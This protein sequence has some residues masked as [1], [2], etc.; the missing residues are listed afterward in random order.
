MKPILFFCV[1]LGL[2]WNRNYPTLGADEDPPKAAP[3]KQVPTKQVPTKQV[4]T[5]QVPQPGRF[6][7]SVT[8]G[9]KVKS[10]P[11]PAKALTE[12]SRAVARAKQAKEG[13]APAF[14]A[15]LTL[16]DQMF[17]FSDPEAAL[18]A[19]KALSTAMRDLPKLR[20]GLGDLGEIPEAK[21]ET[22]PQPPGTTKQPTG[23]K[24][25]AAAMAEVRRRINLAL[26]RQMVGSGRGSYGIRMPN[27]ATMQQT[28]NQELE[29][30]RQEGLLPANASA[31]NVGAGFAGGDP[32]E[33]KKEAIVQTLAFAFGRADS[34]GKAEDQPAEPKK[35]DA[36][37]EEAKSPE[38]SKK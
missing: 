32:K 36:K 12:I 15:A 37:P 9:D 26:Q 35:P 29:K 38:A 28:I 25:N 1:S 3:T 17:T 30:A 8:S 6:E 22:Q 19:C 18:D 13:E 21:P 23:A 33:A 24:S 16:N 20:M 11:H 31:A 2:L 4:P 27:P 10:F 7:I 5:K 14:E 34:T